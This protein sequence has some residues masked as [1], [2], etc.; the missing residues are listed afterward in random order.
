MSVK[1]WTRPFIAFQLL[2]SYCSVC[3]SSN[4]KRC[5][6]VRHFHHCIV[7]HREQQ[8]NKMRST[9]LRRSTHQLLLSL[10]PSLFTASVISRRYFA[11]DIETSYGEK[12]K[13][14]SSQFGNNQLPGMPFK[15]YLH[16]NAKFNAPDSM[17][18][19]SPALRSRLQNLHW[20]IHQTAIFDICIRQT[21]ILSVTDSNFESEEWINSLLTHLILWFISNTCFAKAKT[22]EQRFTNS[23]LIFVTDSTLTFIYVF[24]CVSTSCWGI[25]WKC[26]NKR[27]RSFAS[28]NC[29]EIQTK[30]C[31]CQLIVIDK[32]SDWFDDCGESVSFHSCWIMV[33]EM[34]LLFMLFLVAACRSPL[35]SSLLKKN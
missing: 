13:L 2:R 8:T 22:N 12:G 15:L 14:R 10:K 6:L 32:I 1:N 31:T 27:S 35:Q 28:G 4:W 7:L 19:L 17:R 26:W 25:W 29:G 9:L 33:R 21:I 18:A 11:T 23:F 34:L 16:F 20:M 5:L 3:H 30:A 24:N